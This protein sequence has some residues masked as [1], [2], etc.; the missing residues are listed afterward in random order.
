MGK[1]LRT[2]LI[3]LASRHSF[4]LMRIS[5]CDVKSSLFQSQVQRNPVNTGRFHDRPFTP[6]GFK[7]VFKAVYVVC[8]I[9]VAFLFL[10]M[11]RLV[12]L[13][14]ANRGAHLLHKLVQTY[15]FL[16]LHFS[17]RLED[18]PL[19]HCMQFAIRAQGPSIYPPEG[20]QPNLAV[21]VYNPQN[22]LGVP[23]SISKPKELTLSK[24]AFHAASMNACV[25]NFSF[26][27]LLASVFRRT[28]TVVLPF[29][30][31]LFWVAFLFWGLKCLQVASLFDNI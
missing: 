11:S 23:S 13:Q 6:M 12:W 28:T 22:T 9:Y 31:W 16:H 18:T 5:K 14:R 30:S 8:I 24:K 17:E 19:R 15:Y 4:H 27:I 7:P 29:L 10:W 1:P 25:I 26:D 20:A 21:E 3:C 2:R